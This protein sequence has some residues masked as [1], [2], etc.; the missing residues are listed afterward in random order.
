MATTIV[1]SCFFG[2]PKSNHLY[3]A[4]NATNATCYFFT[5]SPLLCNAAIHVGWIPKFLHDAPLSNDPLVCALQSKRIKFLQDISMLPPS[6]YILYVDHKLFLLPE[7]VTQ[8]VYMQ[9]KPKEETVTEG[10]AIIIRYHECPD[11]KTIWDE[12]HAARSQERYARY[13]NTTVATL[14]SC[15]ECDYKAETQIY[16]T[17]LLLFH[18]PQLS[19]VQPF[20]NQVYTACIQGKQPECQVWW[21]LYVQ[22]YRELCMGIPFKDLKI[23]WMPPEYF[24]LLQQQERR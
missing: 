22:K 4:P 2:N 24:V 3:P 12:I 16:N 1:I 13:I 21:A 7:H 11:H 18:R 20:L 19:N 23:I 17:G 6:D 15:F 9:K 8:L 10:D 14:Q 5:N